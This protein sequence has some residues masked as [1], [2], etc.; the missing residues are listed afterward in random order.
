[1]NEM[2]ESQPSLHIKNPQKQLTAS[3]KFKTMTCK[4]VDC[5]LKF[6]TNPYKRFRSKKKSR[7]AVH[8]VSKCYVITTSHKYVAKTESQQR[9]ELHIRKLQTATTFSPSASVSL[10][11]SRNTFSFSPKET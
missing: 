5:V 1:M 9:E 6:T 10:E 2:Q 3:K 11:Q 8:D 4:G 7:L